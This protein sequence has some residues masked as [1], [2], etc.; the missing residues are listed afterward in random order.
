MVVAPC[1]AD[2]NG[3]PT[4]TSRKKSESAIY[5]GHQFW[6]EEYAYFAR[7]PNNINPLI[8]NN[9]YVF[10]MTSMSTNTHQIV[11]FFAFRLIFVTDDSFH[12]LI[13]A[14]YL[15]NLRSSSL[16]EMWINVGRP[17]GVQ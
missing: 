9:L 2:G 6:Q 8:F 1:N 13:R 12:A 14:D 17:S 15:P 10:C 11:T 4:P 3:A 16:S 5:K 7:S